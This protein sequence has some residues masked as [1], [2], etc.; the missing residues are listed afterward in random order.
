MSRTL[1]EHDVAQLGWCDLHLQELRW[2]AEGRDLELSL[3]GAP[4]SKVDGVRT[5]RA[6]WASRLQVALSFAESHSGRPLTWDV[7]FRR[8]HGTWS[9]TLDFAGKG[10]V[11]FD[12]NELELIEPTDGG[13]L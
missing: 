12:C 4:E 7:E 13:A 1:D 8:A 5:L 11:S 10:H 6:S 9:V 2:V 3:H